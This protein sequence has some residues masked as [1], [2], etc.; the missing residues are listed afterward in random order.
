MEDIICYPKPTKLKELCGWF[1]MCNQLAGKQD[2]MRAL[3]KKEVIFMVDE[4]M[5]REFEKTKKD[6]GANNL[7]NNFSVRRSTF[8]LT[9]ASGDGFAYIFLQNHNGGYLVIQVGSVAIKA[10]LITSYP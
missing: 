9:D 6:I 4:E 7:L 2:K 3:L 1:G 10:Q 5:R 8:L